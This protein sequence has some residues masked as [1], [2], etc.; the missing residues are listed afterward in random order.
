MIVSDLKKSILHVAIRGELTKH[1]NSNKYFYKEQI[2]EFSNSGIRIKREESLNELKYSLPS[3]WRW[4]RLEEV[5]SIYGRIGFRGYTTQ[6][7]V[8]EGD[9]AIT[10]S[11]SNIVDAKMDYSSCTYISWQ[12]YEESPEIK[13]KNDDILLVKTVNQL[14]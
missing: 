14:I 11:P 12:K 4:V 10:L 8:S 3:N 13:I 7:L 2:K 5:A 6:D 1:I 9:G